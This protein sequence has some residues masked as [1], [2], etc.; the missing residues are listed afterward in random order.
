LNLQQAQARTYIPEPQ[1]GRRK[2]AGKADEQKAVYA[3]RR[4]VQGHYGKRLL[5][6]RGELIERSFAHCY[7]TGALRRVYL[8]GRENVLKRQ[9]I[10]V[11]AF[12]LSLIF[13]QTLGAGTPRELRNRHGRII[14]VVFWSS[15]AL[16]TSSPASRS[17]SRVPKR[18]IG[19][20]QPHRFLNCRRRIIGGC[21]TG[22]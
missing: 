4:R 10:H 3:N 15:S 17:L 19:V 2:W 12:N 13:R 20:L 22:C 18:R 11:G 6:K 16:Q 7:E 8:R 1:R 9:L 14:L 21:A 5:K